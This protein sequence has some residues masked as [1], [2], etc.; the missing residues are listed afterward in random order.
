MK[1]VIVR[2]VWFFQ[3]CGLL[4][5]KKPR[6]T[7]W[8]IPVVLMGINYR[9]ILFKSHS[10]DILLAISRVLKEKNLQFESKK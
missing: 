4:W 2:L 1:Q 7:N 10:T 8:G 9:P 5:T 6:T 3:K